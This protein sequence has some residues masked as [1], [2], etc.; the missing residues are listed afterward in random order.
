MIHR[1]GKYLA[2]VVT[3]ILEQQKIYLALKMFT[4]DKSQLLQR[5]LQLKFEKSLINNILEILS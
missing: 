3:D 1:E 2:L 5:G 4:K